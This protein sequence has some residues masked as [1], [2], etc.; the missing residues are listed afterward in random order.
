MLGLYVL[1]RTYR[2]DYETLFHVGILSK[3]HH[4][5][6]KGIGISISMK[7]LEI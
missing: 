5:H 1:R 2:Q 7:C 3:H 4:H 6:T